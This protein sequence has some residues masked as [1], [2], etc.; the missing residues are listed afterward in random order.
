[1][2]REDAIAHIKYAG[3]HDDMEKGVRLYSE[4]KVSYPVFVGAFN[5]GRK[6]QE[7]GVKCTC[8]ECRENK[9]R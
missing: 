6:A 8:P 1:M 2:K 9:E 7:R 4:N 3:Y 5:E